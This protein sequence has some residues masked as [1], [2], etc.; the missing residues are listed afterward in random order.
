MPVIDWDKVADYLSAEGE[1]LRIRA[2]AAFPSDLD[3]QREMRTR[4]AIFDT[5]ANALR[6][7]LAR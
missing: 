5:L 4:A 7:G 1:A 6:A 3:V 2:H